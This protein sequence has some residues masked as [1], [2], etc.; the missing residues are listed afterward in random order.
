MS[1]AQVS[2]VPPKANPSSATY[3]AVA[4][5]PRAY[6]H[7]H[8]G[9]REHEA[10]RV[11]ELVMEMAVHTRGAS[12]TVSERL[13]DEGANGRRPATPLN[14]A[15]GLAQEVLRSPG[16]PLGAGTR[17]YFESRFG[18]DFSR[19]RVHA[20][21]ADAESARTIGARA[22]TVGTDVVFGSD[23]HA[24]SSQERHR[25]LA[26]ELA[27][28]VQQSR[29]GTPRIDREVSLDPRGAVVTQAHADAM[30][31][32]ELAA[33]IHLIRTFLTD[34]PDDEEVTANLALL[35]Q[36]VRAR[37]ATA[38]QSAAA[39]LPLPSPSPGLKKAGT[40]PARPGTLGKPKTEVAAHHRAF[41]IELAGADPAAAHRAWGTLTAAE[42]DEVVARLAKSFGTGFAVEFRR[43]IGHAD[44]LVD[45]DSIRNIAPSQI[46]AQGF[47]FGRWE[48]DQQMW[49]RPSGRTFIL[50]VFFRKPEGEP[51]T[52][53]HTT[54]Q[55]AGEEPESAPS[56]P[57]NEPSADDIE[58]E[59]DACELQRADL[60][61]SV[62]TP[63]YKDKYERYANAIIAFTNH[64]GDAKKRLRLLIAETEDEEQKAQ[65][66]AELATMLEHGKWIETEA[67]VGDVVGLPG[68][69]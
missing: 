40:E 31:D 53:V 57:V 9:S 11:A 55:D 23:R 26:H 16:E 6:Q 42:R 37:Q 54:P 20:D 69:P 56:P 58:D 64:V 43:F 45:Q 66:Q 51:E 47:T 68:P 30:T 62:G 36:T 5:P 49:Y 52:P 22:F 35:E 34:H 63:E 32:D 24:R 13:V 46:S 48:G 12:P 50:K 59:R 8:V 41:Q 65:M 18:H 7:G 61:A 21:G 60:K 33:Q 1:F 39:S 38:Q 67:N 15:S 28:V 27:H 14:G 25:L 3:H 4:R 29:D 19:V 44:L 17:A 10:D 2:R